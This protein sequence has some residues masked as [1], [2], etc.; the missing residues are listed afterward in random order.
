MK[1]QLSQVGKRFKYEWIFRGV[2]AE[3]QSGNSYAIQ[4]P[5][6]SGKSTLLKILSGHLSPSKGKIS[7]YQD[8]QPIEINQV[9]QSISYAAPY[10]D[11]IEDF[12]LREAIHFHQKFKPLLDGLS[13]QDLIQILAFEKS[14]HKA[15]KYFSSGMKQRLKLVL[16]LCSRATIVLLDE[17]G[18]NLDSQGI[19]W[20]RG[21]IERFHQERLLIIASNVPAD[22]DFCDQQLNILDYKK[23]R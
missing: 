16:A 22:F 11:L 14:V 13:T 12:T 23:K 19:E 8:G 2:D 21:L 17:P 3:F 10:I 7:F 4:G 5:N 20:Y 18:T 15:V 9:Y 6:G 1:V